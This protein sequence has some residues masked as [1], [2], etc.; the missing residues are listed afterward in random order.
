MR[1]FVGMRLDD[2]ARGHL[3]DRCA[4]FDG[5]A[6]RRVQPANYHVTLQFIGEV[7][8][9]EVASIIGVL[10]AAVSR[11]S[12]ATRQGK[13]GRITDDIGRWGAFPSRTH[14]RVVWAGFSDS[15]G[16]LQG[17]AESVRAALGRLELGAPN[18]PFRAHVTVGYPRRSRTASSGGKMLSDVLRS[19]FGAPISVRFRSI[20]LIKSEPGAAGSRY[21]DLAE[22]PLSTHRHA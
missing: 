1:V 17:L 4:A 3:A 8:E 20:A 22:W 21:T 14:P 13:E 7:S 19:P 12:I 11:H 15:H 2:A 16:A 5:T 18:R 9:R 10:D 6:L